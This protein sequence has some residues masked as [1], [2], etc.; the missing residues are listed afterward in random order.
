MTK[1]MHET[2][3]LKPLEFI[4]LDSGRH[5]PERLGADRTFWVSRTQELDDALRHSSKESVWI[6]MRTSWMQRLLDAILGSGH[7]AKRS[8]FGDLVML[9]PPSRFE[10]LFP[11]RSYFGQV[12]GGLSSFK[13][14][15]ASQL[16]EVLSSPTRQ[17]RFIGGV[18][19]EGSKTLTLC[20]G[21]LEWLVVPLQHFQ[22]LGPDKPSFRQ[23]GLDDYGYTIRFGSYEASAHSVLFDLDPDYR[24]RYNERRKANEKG[25]GPSL[26][27]LRLLRGLSR[28]DFPGIAGKTIARIERGETETP[29][30]RT[31]A[32][33][34]RKL[35]VAPDD[36]ETY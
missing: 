4:V 30:G 15:P 35:R 33:L 13:M 22:A 24:R 19:D 27:R 26:R 7:Q 21:N 12:I 8:K 20:R 10:M 29:Q 5:F 23:F 3:T 16:A 1:T 14:L 36:I 18:V 25:F 34:A 2:P 6:V 31:I 17:D 32:K 28:D 9:Q 11:L